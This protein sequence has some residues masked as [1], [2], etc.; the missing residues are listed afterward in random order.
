MKQLIENVKNAVCR[1]I[2]KNEEEKRGGNQDIQ[3][4]MTSASKTLKR[5]ERKSN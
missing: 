3:R 4:L 1:Q 5:I 2:S